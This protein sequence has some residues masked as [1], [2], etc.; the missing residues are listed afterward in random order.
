M[1]Y[2]VVWRPAAERTL[3]E[4]WLD[5]SD[6]ERVSLAA[7]RI[8]LLLADDPKRTGESRWGKTRVLFLSPLAVYYDVSD[9]DRQGA[10]WAVWR[11]KRE[12]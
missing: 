12:R 6:Q 7:D 1:K 2:T 9:D 10:V 8:D 5:S 3:T 4:L 11:Q